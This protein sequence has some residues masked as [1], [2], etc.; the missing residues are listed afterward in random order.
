MPVFFSLLAA[1][2]LTTADDVLTAV[3][4][5]QVGTPF[6]LEGMNL[7][8]GHPKQFNFVLLSTNGTGGTSLLDRTKVPICQSLVPGDIIHVS[9]LIGFSKHGAVIPVCTKIERRGHTDVPAPVDVTA[10]ELATGRFDYRP[11]RLRG[12]AREVFRDEIDSQYVFIALNSDGQSVYVAL[13]DRN[14]G[15][16]DFKDLTDAEISVTGLAYVSTDG[17]RRLIGRVISAASADSIT[18]LREPPQDPF[19]VPIL[20]NPGRMSPAMVSTLRR[21]RLFGRV[22]AVRRNGDCLLRDDHGIVHKVRP[23]D[24]LPAYGDRI[25]I[26]GTPDTDLYR[27]NLADAIWRPATG[28][29]WEELP[30]RDITASELAPGN[31]DGPQINVE[32]YGRTVRLVGTVLDVPG[33]NV[34]RATVTLKCGGLTLPVDFG[35]NLEAL[36]S[37]AI[38][39][40]V[41]VTATCVIETESW[42]QAA[43]FP[44]ATGIVLVPRTADDVRVLAYPPWWTP[45]RL[46][47][48]VAVLLLALVGIL[49]WNR[50]LQRIIDRKSRQLLKERVAQLKAALRVDERTHLAVELHDS[51]SQN[52]SG[53]ACQIAATRGT[54]PEGADVTAGY[55]ATAERMLLSCRTELRR[56]LW[57]LRGDALEDRDFVQA[58]R[59]TLAPVAI[60]AELQV[61]FNVSRTRLSDTTAHSVLCIIRELVANAIRHGKARVIRIAGE[62]HDGRLAFSVRDD[63]S[64]F[65]RA[66]CDGPADGHFGLEGI[67]E[68]VRRLDGSF[69]IVSIPGE[70]T[71]A[72][73]SLLATPPNEEEK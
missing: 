64:G 21:R 29:S 30:P 36:D 14:A 9:G 26:V 63:G 51:L 65:D 33:P 69:D 7:T 10:T 66:H 57:D 11:I 43:A 13:R 37:L 23:R 41:E 46:M 42:H 60:G 19:S 20:E 31:A 72:E 16:R 58:I 56:C 53:V 34:H 25:E 45:R 70:G 59:K 2:I 49:I 1:A 47:T 48:V 67:R 55:L 35:T 27:L 24:T 40:T 68:R 4:E 50:I 3:S 62:Y 12:I 61:R 39:C 15:G 73:V 32:L 18:V 28:T 54:L 71:R 44:H 6:A 52:L 38:G 5:Q 17:Q 8:Q 22:I